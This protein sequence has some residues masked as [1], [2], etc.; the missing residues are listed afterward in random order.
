M[1]HAPGA[2][3]AH[4]AASIRLLYVI[5]DYITSG[6][7]TERQLLNLLRGLERSVYEPHLAV[8]RSSQYV[9]DFRTSFPCPVHVLNID[10]LAAASA[11]PKLF[12]LS[13]LVR[14]LHAEIAHVFFKDASI[15]APL[16]CRLGG[17]YTVAARRDMG[18]WY[19]HGT[20]AALRVS[21]RFVDRIAANSQAV[22]HNVHAREGFPLDRIVVVPN[23]QDPA[24]FDVPAAPGFRER[25]GIAA[26]EPIVGMVANFY[27]RKRHADLIRALALIRRSHPGAHVVFVGNEGTPAAVRAVAAEAALANRVHIVEG[28]TDAVPVVKHFDVAV[29]C[30]DS[31]GFSNALLEYA[32]CGK[33]VVCTSVGGNAELVCDGETGLVVPCDDAPALASA[34]I[35]LLAAPQEARRLGTNARL[36]ALERYTQEA[37]ISAHVRLYDS[38]RGAAP[39]PLSNQPRLASR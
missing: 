35:R 26:G 9:R 37:M 21:N 6:A 25:L 10:R 28:V 7:G 34:V 1:I 39:L 15:S 18:F 4:G 33:P 5:D 24:R 31:E 22:K 36:L 17:A 16:F 14:R 23:G 13:R 38:V 20:L 29:L 8:F 12:G 30:S 19:E 11:I 2:G 27:P 32:F 3:K